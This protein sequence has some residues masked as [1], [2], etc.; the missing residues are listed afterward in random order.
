MDQEKLMKMPR[1]EYLKL[2]AQDE[3]R[4]LNSQ[5]SKKIKV[6]LPDDTF[7]LPDYIQ[8]Y[9]DEHTKRIEEMKNFYCLEPVWQDE[10][11]KELERKLKDELA[12]PSK[13]LPSWP[14]AAGKVNLVKTIKKI[15]KMLEKEE[16]KKEKN[17]MGI[18]QIFLYTKKD[19]KVRD[20]EYVIANTSENAIAKSK[21]KIEDEDM[22]GIAIICIANIDES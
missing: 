13:Y 1:G 6:D 8:K 21:I 14:R 12:V 7:K 2:M 9:S 16:N 22:Y 4:M 11:L 17:T 10:T 15:N 20:W 18:Y 5:C 3:A 19:R